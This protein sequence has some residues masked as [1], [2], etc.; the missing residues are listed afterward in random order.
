MKWKAEDIKEEEEAE[1]KEGVEATPPA[2]KSRLR[3]HHQQESQ[4][5][6]STTSKKS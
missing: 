3:Q 1:A 6:G 2:G 5:R 4:G